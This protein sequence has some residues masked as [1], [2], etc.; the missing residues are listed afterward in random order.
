MRKE[1]HAGLQIFIIWASIL[2]IYNL[3]KELWCTFCYLSRSKDGTKDWKIFLK[4][5]FC[6]NGSQVSSSKFVLGKLKRKFE[7]WNKI[8]F[9]LDRIK[10][11]FPIDLIKTGGIIKSS[12]NNWVN[13]LRS[14]VRITSQRS[15]FNSSLKEGCYI[16]STPKMLSFENNFKSNA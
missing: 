12:H 14:M 11:N 4:S 9:P 10:T 5:P 1:F 7:L 16:S 13:Y 8:N 3:M 15:N 6:N 2:Y